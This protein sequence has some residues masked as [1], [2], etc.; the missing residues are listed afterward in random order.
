MRR[1]CCFKTA[2]FL[3]CRFSFSEGSVFQ[4]IF[5]TS[6]G[7]NK[8][9]QLQRIIAN[10]SK[11]CKWHNSRVK[12]KG[13]EQTAEG[14]IRFISFNFSVIG[15]LQNVFP[16]IIYLDLQQDVTFATH[17]MLHPVL[18]GLCKLSPLN[19]YFGKQ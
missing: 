19:G 10:R 12:N 1:F 7:S 6:E 17:T 13:T 4:I 8:P 18:L 9:S 2:V 11:K 15:T 14:K 5:Q 16:Y 3:Y